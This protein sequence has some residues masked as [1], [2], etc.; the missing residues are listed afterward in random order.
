[1]SGVEAQTIR[2]RS[3]ELITHILALL[4]MIETR[5]L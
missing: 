5:Y 4:V 1:M 3:L 2:L